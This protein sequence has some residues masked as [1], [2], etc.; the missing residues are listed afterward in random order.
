VLRQ[1]PDTILVGEIRDLDTAE[2]ATRAALTG[3][4]VLSTVHTNNT[5]A[6][7]TRLIDIGLEPN[8]VASSITSILAQRLV[9]RIC[10]NCKVEMIPPEIVPELEVPKIKKF[11]KG[12]GCRECKYTGFKGRVGVYEFLV[13]NQELKRLIARGCTEEELWST[14]CG[15]DMVTLFEDGWS[16][17]EAGITTVDEIISKIPYEKRA[18]LKGWKPAAG[19][20]LASHKQ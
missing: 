18:A 15:A 3:H 6:T 17:I 11:F 20:E 10:K 14:A 13:L 16:K 5:I 4:L 9:R 1:D 7:I 19:K 8:L 12:R 2:I